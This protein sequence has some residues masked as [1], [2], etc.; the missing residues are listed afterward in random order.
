MHVDS[1]RNLARGITERV[2]Y[3]ASGEGLKQVPQPQEGV[4]NR[5]A[6]FRRKLVSVVVST[7]VVDRCDYAGL[8]TGRKRLIY[9]RAFDSLCCRGVSIKDSVV[10]TFLKAEKINFTKKADPAP[11]VIQPR[12]PRYILEVGRY[13]KNCEKA[14][15]GSLKRL[16]GYA[17]VLKGL[18]ADQTGEQLHD[19][20]KQFSKPVGVGLD[21]TRF[22]QHVSKEALEWEHSIYTSIY[23]SA[24]LRRLL[25]WQLNNRGVAYADGQRIK[26]EVEGKRMSGDINTG[27]G[28]CL[29]MSAIVITYC[30]HVGIKFR[31][32]NNGDDCVLFLETDDLPRL[33]GLDQWFL[34]F[35]FQLTREQPVFTLEQVEFCQ[36]HPVHIGG[37]WRMVRNPLI[38]MSKDSVSLQSWKSKRDIEYWCHSIGSCGSKL[39]S[40]VPVLESWYRMVKRH[41]CTPS[42]GY[43]D[44][45]GLSGMSYMAAGV[46]EC[47]VDDDA[48]YSF[49]KAFGIL[50]DLQL[51]LEAHYD[52]MAIDLDSGAPMM[53]FADVSVIDDNNPLSTWRKRRAN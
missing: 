36:A 33:D 12:S 50:P 22:D 38:S 30:E 37:G 11:R 43:L 31:L 1:L 27:L 18:N 5:L 23:K 28:N 52:S 3:I 8:Y 17:V 21:A 45:V 29:I 48:R 4:F 34:E 49:Y 40:G 41:G 24:E 35:G 6:D 26:Y 47:E 53:T 2:L 39:S 7:P 15:L 42:E 44:S 13:L 19:N 16:Y 32:A 20:W 25:R 51:A 14:I 46:A 9:E 10:R